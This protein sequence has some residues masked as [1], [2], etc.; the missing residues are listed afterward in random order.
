MLLRLLLLLMPAAA[1]ADLATWAADPGT[2]A[3]LAAPLAA[4]APPA[5]PAAGPVARRACVLAHDVL[6][7]SAAGGAPASVMLPALTRGF[8]AVDAAGR[9]VQALAQLLLPRIL[10]AIAGAGADPAGAAAAQ[11]SGLQQL[12]CLLNEVLRL[13]YARL[14]GASDLPPPAQAAAALPA[15]EAAVSSPPLWRDAARSLFHLALHYPP[16]APRCL[17]AYQTALAAALVPRPALDGQQGAAQCALAAWRDVLG[18]RCF[19]VIPSWRA[20]LAGMLHN[21]LPAVVPVLCCTDGEPGGASAQLA[22]ALV[23]SLG[24]AAAETAAQPLPAL[25][26][27]CSCG[28]VRVAAAAQLVGLHAG[29]LAE[30]VIGGVAAPAAAGRVLAAAWLLHSWLTHP[31]AQLAPG[32]RGAL[33]ASAA[34]LLAAPTAGQEART[35]V[36]VG[37]CQAALLALCRRLC[38]AP[39]QPPRSCWDH[40]Q[41]QQE[42]CAL[43]ALRAAAAVLV[44]ARTSDPGTPYARGV[45]AAACSLADAAATAAVSARWQPGVA[46]AP[47]AAQAEA[48][49]LADVAQ[50]HALMQARC[51][52]LCEALARKKLARSPSLQQLLQAVEGAAAALGRWQALLRGGE[53]LWEGA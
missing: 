34:S 37:S 6:L 16:L 3:A 8:G 14:M 17:A 18:Q 13:C 20:G 40:R 7:V 42:E 39:Q 35:G 1:P 52:A 4:T 31:A 19:Q 41:R 36:S 51:S 23:A 27:E 21:L 28:D 32:L 46:A 38:A 49:C 45:L 48:A 33:L 50:L 44:P 11:P 53:A 5:A 2:R 47:G 30:V 25:D 12:L 22:A 43:L 15:I 29:G 26:A 9:T 24:H 10:Q